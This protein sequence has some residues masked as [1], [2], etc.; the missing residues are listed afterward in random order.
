LQL[1]SGFS[2]EEAA[3]IVKAVQLFL[4][5]PEDEGSERPRKSTNYQSTQ[6]DIPEEKL[7]NQV[8][9]MSFLFAE[10]TFKLRNLQQSVNRVSLFVRNE[11]LQNYRY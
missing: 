11:E 7:H 2:E 10:Q 4:D 5:Y 8:N 1:D 9:F 6:H 3:F